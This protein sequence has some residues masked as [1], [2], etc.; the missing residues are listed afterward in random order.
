MKL[1]GGRRDVLTPVRLDTTAPPAS[2]MLPGGRRDSVSARLRGQ[3][4]MQ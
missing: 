2:A 3:E 1:P 4:V